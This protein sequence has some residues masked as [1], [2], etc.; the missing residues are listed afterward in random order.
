[1]CYDFL[2]LTKISMYFRVFL[3]CQVFFAIFLAWCIVYVRNTSSESF[4]GGVDCLDMF[5]SSTK[6]K[7]HKI[8]GCFKNKKKQLFYVSISPDLFCKQ[9]MASPP[10][11]GLGLGLGFVRYPVIP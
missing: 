9:N 5:F 4:L 8:R 1:M 3:F 10:W 11:L 2:E 6:A 7:L